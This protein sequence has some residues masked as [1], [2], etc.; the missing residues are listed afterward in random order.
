MTAVTID[1]VEATYDTHVDSIYRFFYFK[2]RNQKI[3]E[4]LT[5]EVFITFI[6]AA[7]QNK[8]IDNIK[9]YLYGIAKNI[10]MTHLRKKYQQPTVSFEAMEDFIGYMEST[11]DEAEG[12]TLEDMVKKY[13]VKLPEKQAVVM[14]LRLIEK[15]SLN[16]IA[17]KI[18]KD[19]NY[20]KT[21]QKRGIK[22]L[23][24]LVAC[25]P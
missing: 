23:R 14:N 10:F 1:D 11:N 24:E 3:A 13:I 16:Q 4:D 19:M 12:E 17:E 20:V 25:T 21:T 8:D 6:R 7:R 18:G 15:Y 22:R 5:S 2:L 9:Q